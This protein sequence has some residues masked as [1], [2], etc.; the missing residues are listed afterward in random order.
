[1]QHIATKAG[2]AYR[3]FGILEYK[4]ISMDNHRSHGCNIQQREIPSETSPISDWSVCCVRTSFLGTYLGPTENARKALCISPASPC[5]HRSGL[6]SSASSPKTILF[7]WRVYDGMLTMV[8]G[9]NVFPMTWSPPSGT[10][11]GRPIPTV[12]CSRRLSYT[13]ASRYFIFLMRSER[14]SSTL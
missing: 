5:S 6:N 11:R 2:V 8:P 1:M 14:E 13:I 3:S 10:T 12:E 4:V 7:L 9:T